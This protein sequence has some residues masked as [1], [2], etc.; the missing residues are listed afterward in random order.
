MIRLM[1]FT[2]SMPFIT[3]VLPITAPFHLSSG[4]LDEQAAEMK[5]LRS[6]QIIYNLAVGRRCHALISFPFALKIISESYQVFHLL[7]YVTPFR[8]ADYINHTRHA[9]FLK[10]YA[11]LVQDFFPAVVYSF[12]DCSS[13]CS[14]KN[15]YR[16]RTALVH[17]M[18]NIVNEHK[19]EFIT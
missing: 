16:S 12:V 19:N 10:T 5:L 8:Q 4:N 11:L 3:F 15:D 2:F 17:N 1:A 13:I 18:K 9:H 14:N 7:E 6:G